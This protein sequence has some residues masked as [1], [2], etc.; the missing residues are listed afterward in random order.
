MS[1]NVKFLKKYGLYDAHKHFMELS[2]AYIPSYTSNMDEADDEMDANN[3]DQ[4]GAE[5]QGDSMQQDQ[6]T[7]Q[8]MN[9][10]QQQPMDGDDMAQGGMNQQDQ[11]MDDM[12]MPQPPTPQ[13]GGMGSP[14][15]ATPMNDASDKAE[16]DSTIDIDGLTNAQD[17][18]NVKQNRLGRDL[19]KVGDRMASLIDMIGSLQQHLEKNNS[20]IE[21]LKDEFEKRNPTQT[22]RLNLRSL[23]S[24]PFN[25]NPKSYWYD[26]AKQGGYDAYSDNGEPTTQEYKITNDDVDNPSRDIADTFFKI[27]D[28]DI[29]T[30][31]KLFKL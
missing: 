22:E 6:G 24:Y 23:D 27:D 20:E 26:K 8:D 5:Q 16:D 18:L 1:T 12:S 13:D 21:A 9:D 3:Q 14:Q 29:Q 17:K 11:G 19:S 4:M 30:M 2:E 7:G 31:N 25:T 28:D 15:D 10:M